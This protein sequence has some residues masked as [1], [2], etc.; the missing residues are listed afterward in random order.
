MKRYT[1]RLLTLICGAVMLCSCSNGG[2]SADSS[3]DE[4]V[5]SAAVSQAAESSQPDSSQAD[6]SS[7]PADIETDEGI[8][9]KVN[10]S[11]EKT[12]GKL[13]QDNSIT[14][15]KET[16]GEDIAA[17]YDFVNE[18]GCYPVYKSDEIEYY[19]M[20]EFAIEPM[21]DE[22]EAAQ[23][24]IFI[25]YYII[26]EGEFWDKIFDVLKRK[27][28]EGV[29]VRVI[30][31]S[32]A[33]SAKLPQDFGD[34]LTESGIKYC[35]YAGDHR[36][37]MVIDGRV[38]F[39]GGMNL[40]D[41]YVNYIS[42]YGVWKDNALK[43]KGGAVDSFTL[44]FLQIWNAFYEDEDISRFL[45]AKQEENDSGGYIM[46]YSDNPNDDY[47]TAKSFYLTMLDNAK[48]YIYM[49]TPYYMPDDEF[50][51]AVISAAK[52]GVEVKLYVPGISDYKAADMIV[53]THY[54]ALI[55]AGVR[56]FE[57][58]K[59]FIHS[60]IFVSDDNKAIV[61]TVNIDN[62]SFIYDF[63]CAAYL[64]NC[65]VI[66]DIKA[67]FDDNEDDYVQITKDNVDDYVSAGGYIIKKLEGLL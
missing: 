25:E 40:A 37:I 41:E 57:F 52:R 32:I 12:K 34:K 5:S 38:A 3:A 47:L 55:D 53:R 10:L 54:R 2:S 39:T 59:G 56:L 27:A 6:G 16:V 48:D 51:K 66:A 35:T 28:A 15:D 17:M 65:P 1:K 42:P 64:Y 14:I 60:K 13:A 19:I 26:N 11:I 22:L 31:D 4:S 61:G 21:L 36:K 20:G 24:Y 45:C 63:E 67:E 58:K 23:D 9:Q 18:T 62:R 46:P 33:N 49:A 30:Y 50:E 7:K 29:E 8:I 44:M 43:I